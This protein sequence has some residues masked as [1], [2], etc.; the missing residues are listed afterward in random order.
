MPLA[1]GLGPPDEFA[2]AKSTSMSRR[3]PSSTNNAITLIFSGSLLIT[4]TAA[5]PFA[6]V[7]RHTRRAGSAERN[8]HHRERPPGRSA[9]EYPNTP[10]ALLSTLKQTRSFTNGLPSTSCACA[11]TIRAFEFA[12]PG[13][14]GKMTRNFVNS[15]LTFLVSGADALARV[16]D[17]LVRVTARR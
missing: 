8:R 11:T 12:S 3:S 4:S 9:P 15:E 7:E 10:S 6:S 16:A 13:P 1:G 17:R 14:F 5:L 2:D